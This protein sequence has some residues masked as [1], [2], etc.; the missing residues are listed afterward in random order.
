MRG[1][2]ALNYMGE[3]PWWGPHLAYLW[4]C[5]EA[6]MSE[7]HWS[8]ERAMQNKVGKTLRTRSWRVQQFF[9]FSSKCDQIGRFWVKTVMVSFSFLSLSGKII[10]M[11]MW[12]IDN[13]D[14]RQNPRVQSKHISVKVRAE[15]CSLMRR[16]AKIACSYLWL[17]CMVETLMV[18]G[19]RLP[20]SF[21]QSTCPARHG[22]PLIL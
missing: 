22:I 11:Y 17:G 2:K 10:I 15:G 4:K 3:D 6:R 19:S 16:L 14:L 5:S 9:R 7:I 8:K 18:Q 20:C 13:R 12:K 21:P 1:R